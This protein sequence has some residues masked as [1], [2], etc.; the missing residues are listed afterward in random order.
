EA[1]RAVAAYRDAAGVLEQ[2]LRAREVLAEGGRRLLARARVRVAVTR[3]FVPARDDLAD[4]RRVALGDPAE[5]EE[6]CSR[7]VPVEQ[8]EDAVDV[9]LDAARHRVPALAIDVRRERGD[10]EIVLDVDR[11]RVQ[12][13][14]GGRGARGASVLHAARPVQATVRSLSEARVRSR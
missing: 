3:Q 8:L 10:L 14:G 12:D 6:G 4:H 9:A 7:L 13:T 1:R 5:R 2:R 11:H